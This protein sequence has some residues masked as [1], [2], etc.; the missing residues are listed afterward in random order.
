[1]L[2]G[3]GDGQ[4]ILRRVGI[5][6]SWDPHALQQQRQ[7]M[8]ENNIKHKHTRRKKIDKKDMSDYFRRT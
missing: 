2:D 7:I 6:G 3:V 1:M 5:F 4:L 8:D